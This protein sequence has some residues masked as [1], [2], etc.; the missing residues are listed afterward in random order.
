M[1]LVQLMSMLNGLA[2]ELAIP[3]N[4]IEVRCIRTE[5]NQITCETSFHLELGLPDGSTI[6]RVLYP[7]G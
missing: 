6:I 7:I 1:T 3:V 5:F 4:L 2:N